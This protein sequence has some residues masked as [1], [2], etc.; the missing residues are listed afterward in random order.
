MLF[1]Y[2]YNYIAIKIFFVKYKK[3]LL[4]IF[5]VLFLIVVFLLKKTSLFK[6]T[7]LFNQ[8][9]ATKN[10]LSIS[11]NA[12]IED[13]V[14]KDTDGDEI[15]DWQEGLYGLD[16][17]KKETNP[18]IPDSSALSKLRVEQGNDRGIITMGDSSS[19]TE[20]LTQ[21]EKFSR[22]LF[23]TVASLNQNGQ[24]DQATISALANSLSERVENSV[25]RKVYTISDLTIVNSDTKQTIQKYSDTLNNIYLK[26]RVKKGVP[27]ILQEF[28]ADETNVAKLAE[29]DPIIKQTNQII[30][31]SLKMPVPQSLSILHLNLIND[32][33][34]LLENISDIKLFESDPIMAIGAII[35]YGKNALS[36]ASSA[37]SLT[38]TIKQRLSN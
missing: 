5:A 20:N 4:I 28:T 26:Q 32:S 6:N 16:P 12:T 13:L 9:I 35:Q 24:M 23:A 18:G 14:N 27:T 7:E 30:S 33:Q 36:I 1:T 10:G 38:D 21:T 3:I 19:G 2:C 31:E 37:K 34:R 11:D 15:P 22:E 8:G 17:T 25:Q 29:L